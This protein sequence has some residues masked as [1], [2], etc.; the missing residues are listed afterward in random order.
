MD[1][2]LVIAE[3]H[4]DKLLTKML[5]KAYNVRVDH[6]FG[7]YDLAKQMKKFFE[8]P[9]DTICLGIIDND[10]DDLKKIKRHPKFLQE[11]K[12]IE[13]KNDLFFRTLEEN[14]SKCFVIELFP[15]FEKWILKASHS[16]DIN[17]KAYKLSDNFRDLMKI[18]KS[19]EV[20]HMSN[21]WNFLNDIIH[22][23][24]P[25]IETFKSFIGKSISTK[26]S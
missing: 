22:S 6:S 3:C 16:A 26:L 13:S 20:K 21:V 18:T 23:S 24:S 10:R 17:P 5:C 7:K 15:A 19:A 12:L 8:T 11:F 4:A 25:H 9:Y 14:G 1:N 2:R